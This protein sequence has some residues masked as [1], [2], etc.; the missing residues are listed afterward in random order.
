MIEDPQVKD[1]YFFSVTLGRKAMIKSSRE[2]DFRHYSFN[3][4]D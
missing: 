4:K 1:K 3:K 2:D